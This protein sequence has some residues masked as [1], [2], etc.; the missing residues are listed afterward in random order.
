MR[1]HTVFVVRNCDGR[2]WQSHPMIAWDFISAK[3]TKSWKT[4][5]GVERF[6]KANPGVAKDSSIEEVSENAPR[7]AWR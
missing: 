6:M 3:Y 2:Y 4:R 7:S 5:G 1:I